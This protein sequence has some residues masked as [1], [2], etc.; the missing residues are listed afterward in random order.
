M[1]ETRA[2]NDLIYDEMT[3]DKE[4]AIQSHLQILHIQHI[5]DNDLFHEFYKH[6][7]GYVRIYTTAL[8]VRIYTTALYHCSP[9]ADIC[10]YLV[11]FNYWNM[12]IITLPD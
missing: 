5:T 2:Y 8:Y 12:K 11:T 10:F 7:F 3:D 4:Y 9:K 1:T 6:G